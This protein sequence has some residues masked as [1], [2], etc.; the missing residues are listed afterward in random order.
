MIPV[1][2][3]PQGGIISPL[4]ANV[5]LHYALDLWFQEVVKVHMKGERVS[6]RYAD[7]LRL[8]LRV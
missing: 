4:L 7:D 2:G 6:F 1:S 8:R 5:Y 3:T